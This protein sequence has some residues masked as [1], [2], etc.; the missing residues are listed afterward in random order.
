MPAKAADA[1]ATAL[2]AL[3]GEYPGSICKRDDAGVRTGAAGLRLCDPQKY[4]EMLDVCAA[5]CTG[6]KHR[7]D[8][9]PHRQFD[10]GLNAA[11]REWRQ[12]DAEWSRRLAPKS[13]AIFQSLPRLRRPGQIGD[14]PVCTAAKY[15]RRI[16]RRMNQEP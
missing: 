14:D 3:C 8:P 5:A 1:P 4:V 6:E 10:G 9:R 13:M 2:E 11:G 16:G 12:Q 7:I 15:L